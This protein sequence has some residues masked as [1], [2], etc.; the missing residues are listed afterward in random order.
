[1]INKNINNNIDFLS[2]KRILVLGASDHK[3]KQLNSLL[4]NKVRDISFNN[5]SISVEELVL[6]DL[7]IIDVNYFNIDNIDIIYNKCGINIPIIYITSKF[8]ENT[9]L[10]TKNNSVKNVLIDEVQIEQIYM[11]IKIALNERKKIQLEEYHSYFLESARLFYKL[12]EVKLTKYESA[13]LRLLVLNKNTV[14]T[15]K[16]IES[17][18]WGDKKCSI[19]SMRNIVNKIRDKSFQSIIKNV[20][21]TGYIFDNSEFY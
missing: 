9:I 13:L 10:V 21:K 14:L 1:M 5:Y 7:I 12:Q 2:F 17:Q 20:S 6:Y 15:Y 3:C 16:E 4:E 19:Y 8:D 11:Y 18:V